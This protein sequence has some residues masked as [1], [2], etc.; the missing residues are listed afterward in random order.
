[1]LGDAGL[2]KLDRGTRTSR[3]GRPIT[4]SEATPAVDYGGAS[5]TTWWPWT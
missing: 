4:G 1:V 3:G 5:T 2:I